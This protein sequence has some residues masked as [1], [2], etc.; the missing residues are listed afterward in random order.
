MRELW[1]LNLDWDQPVPI[2]I[3]NLWIDF[4]NQLH[5]L[6][7]LKIPRW[8]LEDDVR[9]VELHGFADASDLA[10]GACLYTRLVRNDGSAVLK[11]VCSK[12]KILPRKTEGDNN[13]PCRTASGTVTIETN[14]ETVGST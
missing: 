9:V 13:A 1:S 7:E 2:E 10:Y 3:A 14:S 4:R 11:L 8:I 12:S 6:N 5:W